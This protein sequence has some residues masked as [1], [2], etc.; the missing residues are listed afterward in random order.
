MSH[1]AWCFHL[2]FEQL[3][4]IVLNSRWWYP[5]IKKEILLTVKLEVDIYEYF[6]MNRV[7]NSIASKFHARF[8]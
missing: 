1:I 8:S 4:I 6:K 7:K 3:N 5:I 2:D